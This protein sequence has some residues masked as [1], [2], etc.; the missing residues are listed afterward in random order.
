MHLLATEEAKIIYRIMA[1][2]EAGET[3]DVPVE[4]ATV[5]LKLRTVPGRRAMV[6]ALVDEVSTADRRDWAI[7][8]EGLIL[9]N[10]WMQEVKSHIKSSESLLFAMRMLELL[11]VIPVDLPALRSSGIPRTLKNRFQTHENP[12]LRLLARQCGHKWMRAIS[13]KSAGLPPIDDVE[14]QQK[15]AMS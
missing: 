14:E 15:K 13:R 3:V 1:A 8:H 4:L 9:L 11:L 5:M 2:V 12:R 7:K 10:E 6:N